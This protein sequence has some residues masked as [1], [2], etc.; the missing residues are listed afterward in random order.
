MVTLLHVAL[1][2]HPHGVV[3]LVAVHVHLLDLE[4]FL[5]VQI[6]VFVVNSVALGSQFHLTGLVL[7]RQ[8]LDLEFLRVFASGTSK[9]RGGVRTLG[10]DHGSLRPHGVSVSLLL[11]DL[12]VF[13]ALQ[14]FNIWLVALIF[15][16]QELLRVGPADG[17]QRRLV[18]GNFIVKLRVR[19]L[20]LLQRHDLHHALAVTGGVRIGLR[21]Q[22]HV[23]EGL[24]KQFLVPRDGRLA[25]ALPE[26]FG[27]LAEALHQQGEL[28]GL[29]AVHALVDGVQDFGGLFNHRQRGADRGVSAA[30][31]HLQFRRATHAHASL[32]HVLHQR[33]QRPRWLL[34]GQRHDGIADLLA[35]SLDLSAATRRDAEDIGVLTRPDIADQEAGEV[36][37]HP[38][39][40]QLAPRGGDRV[41]GV[42]EDVQ[43]ADVVEPQPRHERVFHERRTRLWQHAGFGLVI[44]AGD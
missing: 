13:H 18:D 23:G 5:A 25:V 35:T 39:V 16:L 12:Q 31:A 37:V 32:A 30:L 41:G 11:V 1:V 19:G 24:H 21:H 26:A 29:R 33:H 8:H 2:L 14:D 28:F 44:V 40:Q 9:T 4:V 20:Q 10:G 7:L 38:S 36:G 42:A 27:M 6:A 34:V 43:Q 3:H 15:R 22:F 17:P